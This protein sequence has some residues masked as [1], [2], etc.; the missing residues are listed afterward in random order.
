MKLIKYNN[1][2]DD[3]KVIECCE[4]I[5]NGGVVIFPT[6]TVYGIGVNALD[7]KAVKK[8]FLVKGRP[9]DNPLIVHISNYDMLGQ[10][11][12]IDKISIIERKLM[13]SFW[14]GPFTIILPKKDTIS[15]LVTAGLDTVGV[16]MPNNHVALKLVENAGVPIAAPSANISGKPSGTTV[17]DIIDEIGD[18][19][20]YIIDA[21]M[22]DI[23]IESTVVKL[24]DNKIKILRPGK[25]SKE[26]I[27]NVIGEGNV[28]LDK[29]LFESVKKEEK[30]ES[31]GM[32]HR[33]YAPNIKCI[34]VYSNDEDKQIE[35]INKIIVDNV[36][37]YNNILVLGF[38]EHKKYFDESMF[39]DFGS[40]YDLSEISKNIFTAL[41]RLDKLDCDLCIIE[42]VDKK[43][44]GTGI[45]NRL[46]RACEYNYVEV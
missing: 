41:R 43:G 36:E 46:I 16:R 6:E 38:K 30:V 29:K 20:D 4:C 25:I 3:E 33:H 45:M 11:C 22:C 35:E 18:K 39:I 19:V 26:D 42:G 28:F 8:I 13:D 31:P 34:L 9:S 5:K 37:K 14:P 15:D 27:E 21:G 7:E 17:E 40:K 32:K 10:V 44:I 1:I 23:G 12:D 2:N 24:I